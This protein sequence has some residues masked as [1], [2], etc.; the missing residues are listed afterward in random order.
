MAA[1][2]WRQQA[3]D[4]TSPFYDNIMLWAAKNGFIGVNATY[5]L[6]PQSPWPAGARISPPRF[7]G[8][9]KI[10]RGGDPAASI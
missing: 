1:R 4:P 9:D 7:M 10:A 6:A 8:H 3:D 5:R 2:S